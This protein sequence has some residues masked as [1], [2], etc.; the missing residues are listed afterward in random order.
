[1]MED[2]ITRDLGD[3]SQA[4]AKT[5]MRE[6]FKEAANEWLDDKFRLFGKWSIMGFAAA[7]LFALMYFILRLDGWHK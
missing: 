6:A 7:G 3:L 1:M 5:L 2:P 4:E